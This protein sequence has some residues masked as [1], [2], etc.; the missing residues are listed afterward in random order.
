[1]DNK[2][3]NFFLFSSYNKKVMSLQKYLEREYKTNVEDMRNRLIGFSEEKKNRSIKL[4]GTQ[5][6]LSKQLLNIDEH[7]LRENLFSQYRTIVKGDKVFNKLVR[8]NVLKRNKNDMFKY[9]TDNV[10]V[11]F[12]ET[13][14]KDNLIKNKLQQLINNK[15]QL[16]LIKD[17]LI[18]IGEDSLNSI[19]KR[20][21]YN[22]R[23]LFLV[24]GLNGK[25]IVKSI[26]ELFEIKYKFIEPQLINLF[27]DTTKLYML[28]F[29][30]LDLT[31]N[32]YINKEIPISNMNYDKIIKLLTGDKV[33]LSE[34][35]QF[36]SDGE[37]E[38]EYEK[39]IQ[40]EIYELKKLLKNGQSRKIN[41]FFNKVIKNGLESYFQSLTNRYQIYSENSENDSNEIGEFEEESCIINCLIQS[42]F[43]EEDIMRVK[44]M[45]GLKKNEVNIPQTKIKEIADLLEVNI[46]VHYIKEEL[47]KRTNVISY[48]RRFYEHIP[49]FEKGDTISLCLYN[50]H[51]FILEELQMTTFY[52]RNC[53]EIN[54][55]IKNNSNYGVKI[56]EKTK[57]L[58]NNT[59]ADGSFT[60]RKDM[61][62][63]IDSLNLIVE[64]EKL[65]YFTGYEN[66]DVNL[67]S[68]NFISIP[69]L[70][71]IKQD[72]DLDYKHIT[73]ETLL[74]M[75][76]EKKVVELNK[77]NKKQY[78]LY[79]TADTENMTMNEDK[80]LVLH[81]PLIKGF[82]NGRTKIPTVIYGNDDELIMKKFEKLLFEDIQR[83]YMIFEKISNRE[84]VEFKVIMYFHN[85]KYDMSVISKYLYISSETTKGSMLYSKTFCVKGLFF[86]EARDSMKHF[87][88]SLKNSCEMLKV[89]G[90][91]LE[92]I[93]YSYY[94]Q[95]NMSNHIVDITEYK[96]HLKKSD[97]LLFDRI[98]TE[99]L[100]NENPFEYNELEKTFNPLKYYLFYLR[101]D[102]IITDKCID[103]YN[104]LMLECVNETIF[105]SLTISSIAN[106][107]ISKSGCYEGL[108]GVKSLLR[109]FIQKS[110]YGGK[111]AVYEPT[112]GDSIAD[113]MEDF[114][115]T[116]LY[117]SAMKRL[118][119][120]YGLPC[121]EIF[122]LPTDI[123]YE[124]LIN[125]N[126]DYGMFVVEI[127]LTKINKKQKISFIAG[128]DNSLLEYVNCLE[129]G[130]VLN[131]IVNKITLEDYIKFHDINFQIVKG[132]FWK[133]SNGVNRKLGAVIC[134]LHNDRKQA[135]ND[136]NIALS[137]M[138]KL[139]M[140]SIYGKTCQA[141]SDTKIIYKSHKNSK[142]Y[143]QRYHGIIESIDR[144]GKSVKFVIRN[145]DNDLSLNYVGSLILS[146]SKRIMNEVF[147]T[148]NTLDL[149]VY[150]TD[151]DSI[152]ILKKD[153]E[154]LRVKYLEVYNRNLIGKEL[155]QF[156]TDFSLKY[157][158]MID[159]LG[160]D[161][162]DNYKETSCESVISINNISLD[163]KIYLDILQGRKKNGDYFYGTHIRIKGITVSGINDKISQI[164]NKLPNNKNRYLLI[165]N[166][167][168]VHTE[169]DK[170]KINLINHLKDDTKKLDTIEA[171]LR[172]FKHLSIGKGVHFNLNPKD[173]VSFEHSSEGVKLREE[174]SFKR[175]LRIKKDRKD[176]NDKEVSQIEGRD[177]IRYDN[178]KELFNM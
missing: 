95:T 76:G 102:L 171:T 149:T 54:E 126:N 121:G 12:Q 47:D 130:R 170:T 169:Q 147:D 96:K 63:K 50:N 23:E 60:S 16:S 58:L 22:N 135:K 113:Y 151:T 36:A 127:I 45:L 72:Q 25:N 61:I 105:D 133:K 153:I 30:F 162:E 141:K 108:F 14:N 59:N 42:G 150:Y 46:I 48:R 13:I 97:Y 4:N 5:I 75:S 103:K 107:F 99:S 134:K 90:I 98:M 159:P 83:E 144:S 115:G 118:C 77:R 84:G 52:V 21:E 41:G 142:M 160:G 17:N 29:K 6:N 8:D 1:M 55:R 2:Y 39:L 167:I 11:K 88:M 137:D 120:D 69:S 3:K 119:E 65:N 82:T 31:S 101:N 85:L 56:N 78:Y 67:F 87:N 94:N 68:N 132:C 20:I 157:K 145:Y 19:K 136:N 123:T 51:Y 92:A 114:D 26:N 111:V 62:R 28:R 110:I 53:V 73:T 40:V 178:D 117:P 27:K 131:L 44:S 174:N 32:S 9:I 24:E 100:T 138:I 35:N 158:E 81:T 93:G 140:N 156:E 143:E 18:K 173:N 161:F 172:L 57:M 64:M 80:V 91:K 49:R 34:L 38:L 139:I 7:P 15:F 70:V 128:K 106:K 37:T 79:Y 175:Y 146:M 71:K 74:K 122:E 125:D 154:P 33:I 109:E 66:R 163:P 177:N 112:R 165:N 166:L 86:V 152:H 155:G 176:K 10:K 104:D 124:D 89:D 116:G 164:I 168:E 148:M 43:N 129:D